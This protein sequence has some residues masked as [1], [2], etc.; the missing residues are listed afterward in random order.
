[1][2]DEWKETLQELKRKP[3]SWKPLIKMASKNKV[4]PKS[5]SLRGTDDKWTETVARTESI[6]SC[7]A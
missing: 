5:K 3:K 1:M 4:E 6:S 2:Y 7:A